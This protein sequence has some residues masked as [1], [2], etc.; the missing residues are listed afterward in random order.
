MDDEPQIIIYNKENK[1]IEIIPKEKKDN[2]ITNKITNIQQCNINFT[3]NLF[4]LFSP[5]K[6]LLFKNIMKNKIII[7]EELSNDEKYK[8]IEYLYN[9][10]QNYLEI[11]N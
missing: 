9:N 1:K 3:L 7:K 2:E 5:H 11:K 6:L 4:N 10:L 8:Y